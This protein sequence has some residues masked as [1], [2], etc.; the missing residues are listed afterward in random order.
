MQSRQR[1]LF[2]ATMTAALTSLFR[3][4][5]TLTTQIRTSPNQDLP[6]TL[7][8][9]DDLVVIQEILAKTS[10]PKDFVDGI[11]REVAGL[12]REAKGVGGVGVTD[13]IE[14]IKRRG[15][16]IVQLPMDA[17]LIDLTADVQP[18]N[19]QIR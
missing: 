18:R 4:F 13:V 11:R 3:T 15:Q 17:G 8:I 9:L 6:L 16:Q 1:G 10:V 7:S 5:K 12:E 2:T 14:E 19:P